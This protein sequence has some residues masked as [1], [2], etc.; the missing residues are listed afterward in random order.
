VGERAWDPISKAYG[1]YEWQTYVE[2]AARA[3]RFGSGLV[4]LHQHSN[5]LAEPAQGWSVGIWSINRTTWTTADIACV[6]YNLVSVGLYDTLGPEAVTY[7]INHSECSIVVT[8]ADHIASLL[9][10]AGNMPGLKIIISM[11]SLNGA[12]DPKVISGSELAGPILRTFAAD[13]GVQLLDWDEV[14]VLGQLHE[15]RHTP[16]RPEDTFTICYTSGT[17]GMP[18]R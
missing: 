13:K 5:G 2:I 16:P 15:L 11:D 10:N 8:S 17:T 1:P 12:A 14:E 7:G 4:H 9:H 6:A 18:V 3:N